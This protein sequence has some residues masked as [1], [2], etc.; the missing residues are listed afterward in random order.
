V[1]RLYV[2]ICGVT[3]LSDAQAAAEAGADAV[4]F[5]LWSGSKRYIA[6]D[7]VR[8]IVAHL[9]PALTRVG[10]FVNP[11]EEEVQAALDSGAIAVAQL[12]GN[13]PPQ[14]CERFAGRY[15]KAVRLGSADSIVALDRYGGDLVVVDADA[16]GWGGSGRR[17]AV[18]IAAA[19]ARRR[20]IL[21]AGGLTPDNVAGAVRQIAPYGVDVATGVERAPGVKDPAKVA[22]FIR[23][24]RG[25]AA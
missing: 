1:S 10:V 8:Q 7:E 12:H 2:K 16:P 23:A 5:N 4:G 22:A 11:T 17:I 6:L 19:A 20:H 21:L 9:P 18:P 25:A 3:T 14:F 15:W 13:E 24:A